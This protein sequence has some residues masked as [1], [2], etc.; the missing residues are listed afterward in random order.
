MCS[1][2][3]LPPLFPM[4]ASR[5]HAAKLDQPSGPCREAPADVDEDGRPLEPPSLVFGASPHPNDRRRIS[6]SRT[7]RD[8]LIGSLRFT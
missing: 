3:P 7:R 1:L 4:S 2:G 5:G 8:A 6:N